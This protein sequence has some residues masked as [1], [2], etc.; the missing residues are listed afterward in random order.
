M[1][2]KLLLAMNRKVIN[3]FSKMWTTF[4]LMQSG[5]H[6]WWRLIFLLEPFLLP[7]PAHDMLLL[8]NTVNQL[9]SKWPFNTAAYFS[10]L[11]WLTPLKFLKGKRRVSASHSGVLARKAPLQCSQQQKPVSAWGLV[12]K[13][14][15]LMEES[16]L[17]HRATEISS[18]SVNAPGTASTNSYLVPL[19]KVQCLF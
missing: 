11:I 3:A 7:Y 2:L 4:S 17:M 10:I 15:F 13:H 19:P 1:R 16:S 18:V 6:L 14:W 5:M 8:F 9:E 12:K